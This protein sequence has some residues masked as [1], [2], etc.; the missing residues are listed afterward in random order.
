MTPNINIPPIRFAEF[1]ELWDQRKL[2]DLAEFNP[3]AAL[4]NEFE[5]VDLESV[6]GTEM[7]SHRKENKD[8]AP[9]RAQRVASP[10]DLFY[11]TVR[12]YQKNNYLF[13]LSA[14][15][16]VFSTGYA[17]L[18]PFVDGNFLLALVQRDEFVKA[19][20]AEC[21]GTSYPAINSNN[22]TK[23]EVTC[24]TNSAEQTKI[25]DFFKYLESSIILHQRKLDTLKVIKK[26]LLEK[27]FPKKGEV[28]PEIRFKGFD[29]P[30]E[31]RKLS[32][33]SQEIVAGGDIDQAIL[34]KEGRYPVLANALTND[35]VVGYYEYQYRIKAPA[36]TVTGRGDV[37]WA[38]ARTEDFTPVVRLL[39]ITSK[40][41]IYYLENAINN[42]D[43]TFESTGV[44]QLTVPVL[45]EMKIL[46]PSSID[47]ERRIGDLFKNLDSTITLH[48][49]NL[50]NLKK[51]RKSLL[52]EMFP[53]NKN[54][55]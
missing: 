40:H 19:V 27:M 34:K 21:T 31:Q 25:G 37:G 14:D 12:P 32:E 6:V 47:E 49:R 17:Q 20:L 38:K 22:L 11:Q 7:I 3:V 1:T 15:N 8:S 39:S 41:D 44:P 9:S 48:Q 16:Y 54:N 29:E 4:P 33:I 55:N 23:I 53:S 2:G 28:Y 10:G 26:S 5:Y 35:G 43:K 52:G 36:V 51:V 13:N 50:D 18:R 45:G 46:V 24:P 42:A 30:W